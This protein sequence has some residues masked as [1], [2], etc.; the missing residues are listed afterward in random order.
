M[1]EFKVTR[2]LV[3]VCALVAASVAVATAQSSAPSKKNVEGVTNFTQLDATIACAGATKA[4]SVPELKNMGFVSIVN[5]RRSAEEGADVEA[6]MAAAKAAGLKYFHLPFAAP[7]TPEENADQT[8]EAFLAAVGD[9]ANQPVFVHCAAGGRAAAMWLIKRVRID[10]WTVE[11]AKAE[12][13]LVV[14]NNASVDWAVKYVQ[15]TNR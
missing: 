8:V 3:V 12:A 11:K 9:R 13:D 2:S 7:R 14:T 1:P 15:A 5:L 6:E 10:G 4:S